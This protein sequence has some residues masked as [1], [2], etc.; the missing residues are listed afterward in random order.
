[1]SLSKHPFYLLSFCLV[2]CYKRHVCL[3]LTGL[4]CFM[5]QVIIFVLLKFSFLSY[6]LITDVMKRMKIK[7]V[8]NMILHTSSYILAWLEE[9]C[10]QKITH[11]VE[12]LE[13]FCKVL[14]PRTWKLYHWIRQKAR[15]A[16]SREKGRKS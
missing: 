12:N 6:D 11:N 16:V 9:S 13:Y 4:V 1:M 3:I 8:K 14:G 7:V 2:V 5:Q 10:F 15:N